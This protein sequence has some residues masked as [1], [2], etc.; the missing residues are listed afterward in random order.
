MVGL[1]V[2][3]SGLG[4]GGSQWPVWGWVSVARLGVMGL[5]DRGGDGS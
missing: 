5:S 2:G 1:E 4:G 3:L